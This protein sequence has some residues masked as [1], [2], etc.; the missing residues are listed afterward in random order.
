M[1]ARILL[2]GD[3]GALGDLAVQLC[4]LGSVLTG[5]VEL[6]LTMLQAMQPTTVVMLVDS[7]ADDATARRGAMRLLA[8]VAA[9][10]SLQRIPVLAL[11]PPGDSIALVTVLALGAADCATLPL[12]PSELAARIGALLRRK[13]SADRIADEQQHIRRLATVDAVTGAFNRHYLD[14]RLEEAMARSRAT[15]EPLALLMLDIDSFKPINDVHGHAVGDR[16]LAAVAAQLV[17]NVRAVDTVAR[18]GGDELAVIMPDT[19]LQTA[20]D[21]A[22]RLRVAVADMRLSE[23]CTVGLTVSIGV[24]AQMASDHD[25]AA[26]LARADAALY[27]AKRA[28][29]NS[30]ADAA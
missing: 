26:L 27:S 23:P 3:A 24:A 5:P 4:A 15:H 8:Q 17:A 25:G 7:E 21:V 13:H 12:L 19:D 16:A 11:V 1:T 2:T 20:R 22:E 29:R 28:G 10:P 9:D 6:A 14:S 30:I 18:Y